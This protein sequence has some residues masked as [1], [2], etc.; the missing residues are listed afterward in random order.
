MPVQHKKETQSTGARQHEATVPY[1]RESLVQPLCN[2][3]IANALKSFDENL[4]TILATLPE[5]PEMIHWTYYKENVAKPSLVNF[6]KF[7]ELKISMPEDKFTALTDAEEKKDVKI[8]VD[9]VK[10]SYASIT[11]LQKEI[12]NI[13]NVIPFE[14]MTVENLNKSFPQTRLDKTYLYW[15]QQPIENL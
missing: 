9:F 11:K 1:K 14:Q 8:D 5:K 2:K 15:S 13:K 7:N 6:E 12:E 4:T 10:V 3:V